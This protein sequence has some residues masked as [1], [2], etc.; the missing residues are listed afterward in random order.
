MDDTLELL[1]EIQA[2]VQQYRLMAAS[3]RFDAITSRLLYQ[4]ADEVENKAR[5]FDAA[6]RK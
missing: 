4:L 5:E 6:N 2:C 1:I 3:G